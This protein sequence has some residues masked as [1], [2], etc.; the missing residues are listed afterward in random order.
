[1]NENPRLTTGGKLYVMDASSHGGKNSRV[2][3]PEQK[4]LRLTTDTLSKFSKLDELVVDLCYETYATG[5]TYL[6]LPE[7]YQCVGC[8]IDGRC[9]EAIWSRR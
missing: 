4:S 1:M 7:H 9:F 3:R 8:E 6:E 5:K 2:L